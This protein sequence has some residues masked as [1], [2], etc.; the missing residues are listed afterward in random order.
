MS[1]RSLL[2]C[3]N[4]YGGFGGGGGLMA[5]CIPQVHDT[6]ISMCACSSPQYALCAVVILLLWP[7]LLCIKQRSYILLVVVSPLV[8]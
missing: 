6:H 3:S 7:L 5:G 8:Q 2:L 4:L 1:I